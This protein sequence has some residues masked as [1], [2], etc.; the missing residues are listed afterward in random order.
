[1]DTALVQKI[2]QKRWQIL[3]TTMGLNV[4]LSKL[5]KKAVLVQ[6]K[7]KKVNGSDFQLTK[8]PELRK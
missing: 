4:E 8:F 2:Y 3:E 5:L 6:T 7:F 1:M